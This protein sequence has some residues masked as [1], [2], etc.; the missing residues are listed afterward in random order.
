MLTIYGSDDYDPYPYEERRV[1]LTPEQEE[2]A[3][4]VGEALGAGH[5]SR[6]HLA[7]SGGYISLVEKHRMALG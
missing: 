7:V 6:R 2:F 5:R 1:Q 4:Q 3:Q